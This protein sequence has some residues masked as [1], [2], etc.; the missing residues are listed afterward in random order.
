MATTLQKAESTGL[1]DEL[2]SPRQLLRLLAGSGPNGSDAPA[3]IIDL[4]ARSR[5][6][7]SHVPGSHNIPSGWLIS[8]ELPDGDLILVG[9]STRH[10]ATTIEQLQ[11]QGH[12]RRIRH[13]AGGFGAWQHQDLPVAGRQRM[14][15]PQL[16]RLASPQEA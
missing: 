3:L 5:Y 14:G 9:E 15:W 16:F 12:A 10:S 11:T 8:G 2:L 7:R 1:R 6:R 4:R 13:L